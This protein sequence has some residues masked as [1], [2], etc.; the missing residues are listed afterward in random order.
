MSCE[1]CVMMANE[2]VANMTA[3]PWATSENSSSV[4]PCKNYYVCNRWCETYILCEKHMNTTNWSRHYENN[5]LVSKK[6]CNRIYACKVKPA[7]TSPGKKVGNRIYHTEIK[8]K[9]TNARKVGNRIYDSN[10]YD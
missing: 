7:P 1:I 8:S 5:V 6:T 10:Y 2:G 9:G 3:P 4:T